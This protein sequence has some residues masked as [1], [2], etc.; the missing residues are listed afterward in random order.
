MD[1]KNVYR[2]RMETFHLQHNFSNVVYILFFSNFHIP[3]LEMKKHLPDLLTVI[4]R[5]VSRKIAN[6]K[7]RI[8]F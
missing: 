6:E 5:S 1:A 7:K 2:G 3:L 8:Q 4:Y